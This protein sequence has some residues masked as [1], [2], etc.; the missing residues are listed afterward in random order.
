MRIN[1]LFA[2][3]AV[4]AT[5]FVTGCNQGHTNVKRVHVSGKVTLDTKPLT[6]GTITFE[7]GSGEVP[8]TFDI[9]D[10]NYE[11]K[12]PLG[13]NTVRISAMRKISMKEKMGGIEGPGYDQLVDE[14]ILPARYHNQSKITRDVEE[15]DN[16]FNFDLTSK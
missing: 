14:N 9:L 2:C 8:A 4:G 3:A 15:G 6:T 16:K 12:A 11:G 10:G 7:P 13:K 1:L 5:L